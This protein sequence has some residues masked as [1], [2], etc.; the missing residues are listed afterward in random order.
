MQANVQ[1]RGCCHVPGNVVDATTLNETST[2]I[3][4]LDNRHTAFS[5]IVLASEADQLSRPLLGYLS[6]NPSGDWEG[7]G[8]LEKPIICIDQSAKAQEPFTN[9]GP[10]DESSFRELLYGIENLR[11][12]GQEG[13]E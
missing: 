3:Y 1:Y 11:K 5:T 9:L 6:F 2:I 12:R 4:S 7:I 8:D 10:G 13:S